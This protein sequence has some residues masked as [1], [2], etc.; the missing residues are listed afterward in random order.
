MP[1]SLYK[2]NASVIR[3]FDKFLTTLWLSERLR[4]A[5]SLRKQQFLSDV[6]APSLI[7]DQTSAGAETVPALVAQLRN[8]NATLW[9]TLF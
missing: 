5:P 8:A 9:R 2:L 1:S 4:L 3:S 6:S 7:V